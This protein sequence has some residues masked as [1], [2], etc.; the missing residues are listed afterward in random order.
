MHRHPKGG[1]WG[2]EGL[3]DNGSSRPVVGRHL[4]HCI[5]RICNTARS[6]RLE[7]ACPRYRSRVPGLARQDCRCHRPQDSV[8][9]QLPVHLVGLRPVTHRGKR[10]TLPRGVLGFARGEDS[11]PTGVPS[12]ELGQLLTSTRSRN[13]HSH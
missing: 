5:H 13:P 4:G 12:M 8:H 1:D 7:S 2:E 9:H 11:T 6:S 10:K 3:E